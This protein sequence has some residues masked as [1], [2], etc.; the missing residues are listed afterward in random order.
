M[1]CGYVSADEPENLLFNASEVHGLNRYGI[2]TTNAVALMMA[3][4]AIFTTTELAWDTTYIR[5]FSVWN[6][7]LLWLGR[8][9]PWIRVGII[10]VAI[11][12]AIVAA[13]ASKGTLIMPMLKI[14]VMGAVSGFVIGGL[15]GGAM[16]A[17]NGDGFWSGAIDGAVEGAI[18]GAAMSVILAGTF[19]FKAL[20]AKVAAANMANTPPSIKFV[21]TTKT[22]NAA[23]QP[24]NAQTFK[25]GEL[26]DRAFDVNGRTIDILADV[27]IEGRNLFLDDMIM[28]AKGG[29][30]VNQLGQSGIRNIGGQIN[31]LAAQ[32]GFD[33][34][35]YKFVRVANSSSAVKGIPRSRFFI[36]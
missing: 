15:V 19:G 27:R 35:S 2:T 13:I 7:F 30:A 5:E 33:T 8:A 36:L 32:Q 29:D 25:H 24:K 4:Y 31:N 22:Q 28:Y 34:I 10:A 14:A 3:L 21:S 9:S 26:F 20:K 23:V 1:I 16:S 12:V 11:I 6:R 18:M 17:A